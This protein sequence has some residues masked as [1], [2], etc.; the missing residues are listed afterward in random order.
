METELNKKCSPTV[1]LRSNSKALPALT[2]A[3]HVRPLLMVGL[4]E[5]AARA[6]LV[7]SRP[8]I[9][10]AYNND[11][12]SSRGRCLQTDGVNMAEFWQL[13]DTLVR[14]DALESNDIWALR[15]AYGADAARGGILQQIRSVFGA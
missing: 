12:G 14:H 5:R 1:H 7:R 15:C 10:Q 3:P 4:V 9:H 2:V 11:E 13:D 6:I 8:H